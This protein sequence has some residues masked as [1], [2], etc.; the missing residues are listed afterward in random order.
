MANTKIVATLGPATDSPSA[1]RQ[2]L[3]AGVDVFRLNASHSTQ[4]EH[5]ARIAA[6]R[7]V[8]AESGLPA[9]IL[10]DLQG[11]K[12]R[13]GRFSGG[14]CT[15]A[16]G[17]EFTITTEQITGDCRR[18]GT[19]YTNFAADVKPGDRVLL[20]DGAI[21]L[22]VLDVDGA[23]VRTEV[24]SGGPISDHKGINLP[25][26]NVSLPSLT[27]KDLADLRFGVEQGIDLVALSF[28]RTGSDV[29]NLREVLRGMRAAALPVV[30]KIEKPQAWEN[31]DA[32]LQ[33]AD[34]VM[35]A[36]GDLGVE[37]ALEKV[38]RI[39]KSIIRRARR[40]CKF[41][42]TATQML[43]SMIENPTPTRAE[44]SDVANAIYDGTDAVMLSAETSVGKYPV[45]AVKFMVRIAA[46][47]EKS[48][49][50]SGFQ[51]LAAGPNPSNAEILADAAH[52]AARDA[53]VA[54]IVVFTATG[55]SARLVSRYRPPVSIYAMTPR[56]NV[57]RQ[58]MVNYGVFPVQAPDVA[59]TDEMLAQ[60]D[61]VLTERGCVQAGD[62]VV[63]LAGQPVGRP[64]TT[65]LMKLHRIGD[66]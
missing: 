10:L 58:L 1:I 47:T 31:V 14:G 28:V 38:P 3:Q 37:I 54:A 8:A 23:S 6:I 32:I 11:P 59:S 61:R 34:G 19:T 65:N 21:E 35:V 55:S 42:I 25:G 43:E 63:F 46:E 17:A 52:H 53:K 2:L 64:G 51:E 27:E 16:T 4:A 48:I 30:A 33:A 24:V 50:K 40:H 9:A 60:M 20:A 41:V 26:V 12:I 49:R 22:R 45:E 7:Q 5:A 56:E 57:G 15:L 13:L 66:A 44:V 62:S 18:A 29:V 36:R 39:Q